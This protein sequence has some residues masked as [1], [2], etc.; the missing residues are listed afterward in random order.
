MRLSLILLL[1]VIGIA[2]SASSV[3]AAQEFRYIGRAT[4]AVFQNAATTAD[5]GAGGK[6]AKGTVIDNKT[7]DARQTTCFDETATLGAAPGLVLTG[8]ATTVGGTRTATGDSNP[9]FPRVEST[10]QASVVALSGALAIVAAPVRAIADSSTGELTAIGGPTIIDLNGTMITIP[11]GEGITLPGLLTLLPMS[12]KKSNQDGLTVISVDG[13]ILDP[14]P[15]GPLAALGPVIL[16]HVVA[17]IE[18]PFT[19]GG[20]GGGGACSL[21]RGG[22][23]SGGFELLAVVGLLWLLARRRRTIR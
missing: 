17:G 1:C 2:F 9:G 21:S 18:E 12:S 19:E 3:L 7:C 10:A 14:D 13:S 20:G 23:S 15:A 6:D 5:V 11:A 4:A 22:R 16:G 8:S